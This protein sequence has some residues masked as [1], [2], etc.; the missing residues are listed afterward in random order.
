[1]NQWGQMNTLNEKY[2][3]FFVFKSHSSACDC[4]I[5]QAELG[6]RLI[7]PGCVLCCWAARLALSSGRVP[8]FLLLCALCTSYLSI[9]GSCCRQTAQTF[10]RAGWLA[11]MPSP[12][13][14]PRCPQ[15]S[16]HI[17]SARP[18]LALCAAATVRSLPDRTSPSPR[19]SPPAPTLAP[20]QRYR[21]QSGRL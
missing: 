14:P 17:D 3:R 8:L 1:M 9:A 12:F 5:E 19:Q 10:P 13:K 16:N 4:E 7:W 2:V 20:S 15:K 18:P 11:R 21:S 6:Y